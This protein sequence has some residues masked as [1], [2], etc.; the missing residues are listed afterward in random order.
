MTLPILDALRC[1]YPQ[2]R[3]SWVLKAPYC[4]L[5][6]S[7]PQLDE[8]IP[9]RAAGGATALWKF[10]HNL[11][12]RW[13]LA[14][15]LQGLFRSGLAAWAS[16]APVRV[17]FSNAKEC[18]AL[19]YN[20][21]VDVPG[22]NMHAVDR[23]MLA[24]GAV[25][26][27]PSE[28]RFHLPVDESALGA[29]RRLICAEPG[30]PVLAMSPLTRRL[31]KNWPVARFAAVAA[32]FARKKWRIVI[33][34]GADGKDVVEALARAAGCDALLFTGRPLKE[35]V[36]VISLADVWLSAD[37]GPLHI[38]DALGVPTVSMFGST[39]PERTGPYRNRVG[40]IRSTESCS[41]CFL[42]KCP[43]VRCMSAITTRQ[44][45]ER[46]EKVVPR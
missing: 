28:P 19:F 25:G 15:D 46:I 3:I 40:V 5:L 36:A 18:A 14:L 35:L 41:P 37:T 22:D 16:A 13:D 1:A 29:A 24:L 17:G 11:R 8:A 20:R 9:L 2:A 4:E 10:F 32:H 31:T 33:V 34:G 7:H 6:R 39:T 27:T 26:V 43:H 23:Y 30:Q 42:K 38:A 44:V 21:R 12:R 45:I